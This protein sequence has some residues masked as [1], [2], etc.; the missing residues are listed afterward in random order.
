M[1]V[2][3][4]NDLRSGRSEMFGLFAHCAPTE[5]QPEGHQML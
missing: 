3:S 5:R 4:S 2:V 1:A